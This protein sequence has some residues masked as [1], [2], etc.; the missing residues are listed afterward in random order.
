MS[1]FFKTIPELNKIQLIRQ[2]LKNGKVRYRAEVW[3]HMQLFFQK[4]NDHQLHGAIFFKDQIDFECMKKA[5][6]FTMKII[7]I[8]NSRFVEGHVRSY[9]EGIDTAID[10]VVTLTENINAEEAIDDFLTGK[11]DEFI[12]PQLKVRIVRSYDNDTL[13]I[14][15]NHMIC[16]GAGFKEYLYLLGSIYTNL[17]KDSG[18]EPEY[19]TSGSRSLDQVLGQFNAL[20]KL[21]I[22]RM[23][24]HLSKHNSGFSFPLS[25]DSITSPSIL[26]FKLNSDRYHSLKKYGREHGATINDIV[27]AAYIRALYK[28]INIKSTESVAIPCM[29]DLRRFLPDRKAGAICNLTSTI[30]CDIKSELGES[31]DETVTRVKHAMDGQKSNFPGLNGLFILNSIFKIFTYPTIKKLMERIFVNPLIALT[32]IGIIDKNRLTFDSTYVEDAF[33]T[34]SIKYYPYFQL[35]LTSFND[36]ITFSI[37]VYGSERDKQEIENFF[38]L[39]EQEFPK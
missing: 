10:E 6:F 24:H 14:V 1:I 4:Y 23:P 34:G 39:L 28:V 32:N 9:W 35:A 31:F 12:G 20:G 8:L 3:D 15:M 37:C 22:L 2:N 30:I 18:Y 36:S 16:D 19:K 17:R 11:T 21:K 7:P 13:C 38:S 25:G 27:L 26:T 33:I 5:V 29:I